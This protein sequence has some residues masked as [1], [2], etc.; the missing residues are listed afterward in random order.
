MDSSHEVM[1][2]NKMLT[3]HQLRE[4]KVK[5]DQIGLSPCFSGLLSGFFHEKKS[6][7]APMLP[8]YE[9][10]RSLKAPNGPLFTHPFKHKKSGL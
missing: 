10:K 4:R 2:I 9:R 5:N 7:R 3:R 8:S 1:F 6:C